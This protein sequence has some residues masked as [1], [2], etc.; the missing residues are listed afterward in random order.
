M[1]IIERKVGTNIR[2][3]FIMYWNENKLDNIKL[4]LIQSQFA[5]NNNINKV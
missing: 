3:I 2:N 4:Q 1:Q 5:L